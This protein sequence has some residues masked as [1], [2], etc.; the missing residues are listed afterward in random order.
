MIILLQLSVE[1]EE[2]AYNEMDY[3]QNSRIKGTLMDHVNFSSG[4]DPTND[5]L[6]NTMLS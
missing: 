2:L 3:R 6:I 1:A 4:F 5:L